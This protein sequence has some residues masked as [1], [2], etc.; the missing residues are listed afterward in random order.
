MHRQKARSE[1]FKILDRLSKFIFISSGQ[2]LYQELIDRWVETYISLREDMLWWTK[3]KLADRLGGSFTSHTFGMP[4]DLSSHMTI[5]FHPHFSP[6]PLTNQPSKIGFAQRTPSDEQGLQPPDRGTVKPK[7]CFFD[8][9]YR[10]T[11]CACVYTSLDCLS[12][13]L[14]WFIGIFRC[15]ITLNILLAMRRKRSHKYVAGEVRDLKRE[16]KM[17]AR[18]TPVIIH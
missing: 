1:N 17:P 3:G 7:L 14:S 11:Q 16:K 18:S 12:I 6:A 15:T 9:I 4:L 13:V 2:A 10:R 8:K 5:A